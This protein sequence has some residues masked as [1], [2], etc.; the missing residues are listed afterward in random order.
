MSELKVGHKSMKRKQLKIL[1]NQSNRTTELACTK[2]NKN[3]ATQ[4]SS[5]YNR[6]SAAS[7]IMR[8]A[9]RSA[10]PTA[11]PDRIL[12]P[13][14]HLDLQ[15]GGTSEPM[16][17]ARRQ[18]YQR[19]SENKPITSRGPHSIIYIQSRRAGRH[20]HTHTHTHTQQEE[21]SDRA[22]YPRP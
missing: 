7:R 17:A 9:G 1:Q 6:S 4:R 11:G 15:S 2:P 20:T 19:W 3:W 8:R 21:A 12:N 18:D 14:A 5:Y 13:P 16:A 10:T 22:V